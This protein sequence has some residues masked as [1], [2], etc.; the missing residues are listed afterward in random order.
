MND[1]RRRQLFL[2]LIIGVYIASM[3]VFPGLFR[4]VGISHFGVWFLDSFA[5]LASNDAITRGLDPYAVNPLDYFHRPH[6]YSPWWLHLRDLG[7]TRAQNFGFGLTVVIAF[8]SAAVVRLRPKSG[9]E[10]GWYVAILLSSPVLLAINRANNDLIVFVVLAPVVPC[11]LSPQRAWHWV[12]VGLIAVAAGL[13]YYPAIAGVVLLFGEDRKEVRVRLAFAVVL[14]ALVALSV[15]P[16]FSRVAPLLPKADGLMTFAACKIFESVGM[17]ASTAKLVGLLSGVVIALLSLGS[18]TFVGWQVKREE[19]GD[20]L[21]FL[22]GAALLA[23]CFFTGTNFAYRWVYALWLAPLLWSVA[24]DAAA[25]Q[26]VRRFT[27]LTGVLLL[28]GLWLDPL[29]SSA[30]TLLQTHF[31]VQSV[32]RWAAIFSLFEQP[33][34]WALFACL[35]AYLAHFVREVV[36]PLLVFRRDGPL[37]QR[38]PVGN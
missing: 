32:E 35:L 19:R 27:K 18:K 28:L 3:A 20:W 26:A 33:L 30:L 17:K 24:R 1:V 6:V 7:L 5:L 12:A 23:G 10:L 29:V 9:R 15:A 4:V 37:D 38:L 25:P 2:G 13:K 21:S 36:P 31:G 22:L 34:L 16:D 8:L 14:L 11:L